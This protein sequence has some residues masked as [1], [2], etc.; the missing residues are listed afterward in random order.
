MYDKSHV[1]FYLVQFLISIQVRHI[2]KQKMQPT[3]N[4][5]SGAYCSQIESSSKSVLSFLLGGSTPLST[6][7]LHKLHLSSWKLIIS[8]GFELSLSACERIFK[9][10]TNRARSKVGHLQ[11]VFVCVIS[12]L[13]LWC[14]CKC[15]TVAPSARR[16]AWR[17]PS[18][19]VAPALCPGGWLTCSPS[20][21]P[22]Q[23]H[24]VLYLKVS[25]NG[26]KFYVAVALVI[27]L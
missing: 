19:A 14:C 20:V 7:L 27:A 6:F 21:C 9:S 15:W 10:V 5:D 23:C 24:C 13:L 18:P 3:Q 1:C 25:I 16:A 2:N 8:I 12:Y 17:R 4:Q 22:G 11:H 26:V